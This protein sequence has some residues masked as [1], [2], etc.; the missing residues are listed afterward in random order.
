MEERGADFFLVHINGQNL[1]WY[2]DPNDLSFEAGEVIEII[3]ET[4]ADWWTGRSKAGKQG[5]FPSNYVEKFPQGPQLPSRN[6]SPISFPD[7]PKS[8]TLLDSKSTMMEKYPSPGPIQQY[9]SP[10]PP[11]HYPPPGGSPGYYPPSGPP[12]STV[13]NSY[14]PPPGPPVPQPMPQQPP[15]K[16][17][18]GGLGQTVCVPLT[19]QSYCHSL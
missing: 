11:Q 13:Y 17:K 3:T 12:P 19:L 8:S 1:N 2:Q 15:K 14:M 4:N 6:M 5:L 9:P 10:G 7:F 16:S 18:F